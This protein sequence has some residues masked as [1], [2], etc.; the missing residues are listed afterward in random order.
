MCGRR[1]RGYADLAEL[2]LRYV[3]AGSGHV[4]VAEALLAAAFALGL[5]VSRLAR[6]EGGS[7]D[8]LAPFVGLARSQCVK[9][10]L[11]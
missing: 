3:P 1:T 11:R 8:D 6:P 7:P 5:L 9:V 10:S 4:G 2:A